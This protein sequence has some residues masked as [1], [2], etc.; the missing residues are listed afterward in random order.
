M[1]RRLHNEKLYALYSPNIFRLI[2]SR[3]LKRAGHVARLE[4]YRISEGNLREGDHLE[5]PSVYGRIILKWI[6]EKWDGSTDWIDLPQ[7]RYRWCP[8]VHAVM[9]LRFP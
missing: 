7:E 1:R 9:N 3:K 2:K 4:E 6:F 5:E 8:L